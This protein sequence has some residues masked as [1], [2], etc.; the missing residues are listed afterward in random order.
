MMKVKKMISL[1]VQPHS[2]LRFEDY[3]R[4]GLDFM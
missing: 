4:P 3:C 1:P 2:L